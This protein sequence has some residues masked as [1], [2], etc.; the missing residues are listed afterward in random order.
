MYYQVFGKMISAWRENFGDPQMPFCILSLCTADTPQTPDNVLEPMYDVGPYIREAQYQTFLDLRKAGDKH[1][2][3]ASTFDLRKSWY[4][5]QI[6]IPA[7]ERAAKWALVTDY[8]LLKGRDAE[9]Y[10]LPPTIDKVETVGSTIRLTLSTEVKTHDDSDGKLLGFAIA[11]N[12]RRFYPAEANWLTDGT[13]GNRNQPQ[14]NRSV[15]VLSSRFVPQPVHYRYAWARNPMGN[16]VN[17]QGVPLPAQ[18]SDD[19][20]LEE[21][22]TKI[23]VPQ[24]LPPDAARRQ[25]GNRIRK[26]LQR[27]DL[28]R[29]VKEAEAT[30]AELKPL[31]DKANAGRQKK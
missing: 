29:R 10:W 8:Q 31:L 3:F 15:L 26:E 24:N 16:I 12:D 14:V 28:E 23:A 13:K 1:V 11:G 4:H 25:A 5:P 7:G 27:D 21:T 2:G 17:N 6:K 20:I 30:F 9:S 22:P 19:W 18:R